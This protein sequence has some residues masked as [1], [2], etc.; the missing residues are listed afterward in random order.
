MPSW[1]TELRRLAQAA[2][3]GEWSADFDAQYMSGDAYRVETADRVIARDLAEADALYLAA[4]SPARVLALVEVAERAAEAEQRIRA[5]ADISGYGMYTP[6]S[7]HDFSPDAEVCTPE[8]ITRH[9]LACERFDRGEPWEPPSPWT[10]HTSR[11]AAEAYAARCIDE[12]AASATVGKSDPD[13]TTVVHCHAGGWGMG[14]YQAHDE[15]LVAVADAL[16][17]ALAEMDGREGRDA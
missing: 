8:E 15:D 9:R 6:E 5:L 1:L 11:E 2:T 4:L 10:R 16:R 3:P 7:P 12:G 17:A 14:S 13:G